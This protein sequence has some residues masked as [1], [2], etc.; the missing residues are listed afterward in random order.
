MKSP[1]F[2]STSILAIMISFCAVQAHA[3]DIMEEEQSRREIVVSGHIDD[4]SDDTV[5]ATKTGTAI[6]DTPQSIRIVSRKQLDDQA[7]RSLGQALRYI[8]GVTIGQGEG[9]RDQIT[10]RGQNTTSD[11]FVDGVRDD[12]QYYRGL[13]NLERVEILKG[14]AS[15]LFGRGGG[16]GVI[17]RV[18]KT[19]QFGDS[20]TAG[21]AS[22]TSF[23]AYAATA[24]LN[25]ELSDGI[26]VRINGTYENLNNHRDFYK[27]RVF[28]WNPTA[29]IKLGSDWKLG[30]SYEYVNDD[31]VVDRGIPSLNNAPITAARDR[32]FGTPGINNTELEAQIANVRLEGNITSNLEL[33]ATILYANYDKSYSNVYANG[34][35]NTVTNRVAMAGY[36]D[37]LDRANTIAQANFVWRVDTGLLQHT[38]LFGGEYGTQKSDSGRFDAVFPIGQVPSLDLSNPVF[39]QV[40]F[41]RLNRANKSDVTFTSLFA[42]DQIRIGKYIELLA[43]LRYDRFKITGT[44]ITNAN[45]PFSRTDAKLSPRFGLVLKPQENISLYGSYSQ[46]FQPRSGNQFTALTIEQQNLA[47]EKFVNYEVGA[48][49]APN[50]NL[51]LAVAL[52]QLD[53]TNA[54]VANPLNPLQT[55]NVGGTRIKGAE[56]SLTGQ[57]TQKLQISGGY[58]YQDGALSGN[59]TVRLPQVPKHQASL[60]TRYDVTPELGIGIGVIHQSSQFAVIRTTANTTKLPAFTRVDAAIFYKVNDRIKLQANIENLFDTDYFPDAHNNNNISTGAPINAQFSVHIKF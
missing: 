57:V 2:Y 41:P 60:W 17:N 9:H 58:S 37:Y 46:S 44:E 36:S 11:F 32:F 8:P 29:V 5:D 23:G 10:I 48:K 18:Q 16:G 19:P 1:P 24:D 47:P 56:F 54:T 51:D 20:F 42:Q 7:Q 4:Y 49:W 38:I 6:I 43:G 31:R 55:I 40:Q 52:F 33:S 53:R 13:Y 45:R 35:L 12:T 21:S 27:G 28:A 34:P 15:L 22:I 25:G 14:P 3:E 50:N 30:L 26:A 39:P 59:D